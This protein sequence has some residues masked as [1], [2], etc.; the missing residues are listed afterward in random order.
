MRTGIVA[1]LFLAASI[2][3]YFGGQRKNPPG[4]FADESS[5][6]WNALQIARHGVDEYGI[7]FPLYFRAFGEYKNPTYI[8]L[9]A[10]VLK[11]TGPS[12]LAARRLSAFLG[13]LA[14]V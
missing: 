13:W 1:A 4:F 10:A 2:I 8:Y 6:G 3:F 5:I 11:V 9:L 14:C 12:N 7:R